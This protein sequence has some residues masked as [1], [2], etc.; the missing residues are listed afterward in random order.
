[1]LTPIPS[2]TTLQEH[3][4]SS[5]MIAWDAIADFIDQNYEMDS[6]WSNGGKYGK[7]VLR[8]KKSGKTLCTL[9]VR[10]NQF[11]CWVI[12]GKAEREKFEKD[13][14]LFSDEVQRIYDAA[15]VYHDGKWVMLDIYDDHLIEDIQKMIRLKK[16]PNKK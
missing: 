2:Q 11:G 16:K 5:A 8:F 6:L 7:Y 9:Y 4:G 14:V 15:H 1:M 12:F 10:D 3:L 13:R